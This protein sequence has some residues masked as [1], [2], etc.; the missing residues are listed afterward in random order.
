MNMDAN[1]PQ[2]G[3]YILYEKLGPGGMSDVRK[4]LDTQLQRYVAIKILKAD[5]RN[6]PQ[7]STRFRREA[8]VVAS[9]RHPNI[10][11]IYD[12]QVAQYPEVEEPIAYMVMDYVPGQNLADYIAATSAKGRFSSLEDIVYLFSAIGYAIDYAHHKGIIHRDIK[13][14]NIML[15]QRT[16]TPQHM[17]EPV[18]TDFGLVKLISSSASTLKGMWLGTPLYTSPEQ[19]RGSVVDERSDIYSLGVILYEMC[20]GR[21]PFSGRTVPAI[22]R[23]HISEPPPAPEL[24]NPAISPALAEVIMRSLAKEP[25]DRFPTAS[26]LA[27]ALAQATRATTFA[28]SSPPPTHQVASQFISPIDSE[29]STVTL[30]K[31]RNREIDIEKPVTLMVSAQPSL[32]VMPPIAKQPK[33]R[34]GKGF[35]ATVLITLLI[36]LLGSSLGLGAF[37]WTSQHTT[38]GPA[39]NPIIGHAFFVSSGQLNASGIP[40]INDELLIN[41][42]N[43]QDP[44]PGKVYYAWLLRDKKQPLATPISLGMLAV[45]QGAVYVLYQGGPKHDNLLAITSRLLITEEDIGSAPMSPAPDLST[46]R[47]YAELPQNPDPNDA[48]H[49]SLLDHLRRLL[50]QDPSVVG[51][52]NHSNLDI[53]LLGQTGRV[54]E[55][56]NSA[57]DYWN[58]ANTSLMRQQFLRILEYLDGDSDVRADLPAGISPLNIAS[59]ALLGLPVVDI[60]Q[61]LSADYLHQVSG[62]LSAMAQAPDATQEQRTRIAS[63]TAEINRVRNWLEQVR[64]NAKQLIHMSDTQLLQRDAMTMMDDMVTQ[65]FHAYTGEPNPSTGVIQSGVVQIHNDIERLAAFD[66]AV[67]SFNK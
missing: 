12:Y 64:Q 54:L 7:F 31:P 67:H 18:L 53:W 34:R 28:L 47:Y 66:I 65:A 10:V 22:L 9:L 58:D 21:R 50:A 16:V 60:Q 30:A 25:Q 46:V 26:S 41:L 37:F 32:I 19:A 51:Q 43:L 55:W 39:P 57:R 33:R 48:N 45:K 13:P 5:L 11:Q 61:P 1:P 56:A 17:G 36:A 62:H 38:A 14:A 3:K 27:A 23:Q 59:V 20:T 15:D 4:A 42:H 44:A 40:S 52:D 24:S 63:I 2:L 29:Q 49:L 35:L 6:D 8:Q